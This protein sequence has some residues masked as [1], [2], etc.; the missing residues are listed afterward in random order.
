MDSLR[1]KYHQPFVNI[2]TGPLAEVEK[3][4]HFTYVA[5]RP[6]F[7]PYSNELYL[8]SP[9]QMLFQRGPAF[10]VNPAHS[11]VDVDIPDS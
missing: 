7:L 6:P 11:N 1:K 8:E 5:P 3:I 2:G 4:P 9:P 10:A